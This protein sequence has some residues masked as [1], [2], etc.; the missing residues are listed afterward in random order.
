MNFA[1]QTDAT[2]FAFASVSILLLWVT[3]AE[4]VVE[5]EQGQKLNT[6]HHLLMQAL[7]CSNVY[8]LSTL[9]QN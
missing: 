3:V 5:L 7:C 6:A 9:S 4:S 8:M 2:T 1:P